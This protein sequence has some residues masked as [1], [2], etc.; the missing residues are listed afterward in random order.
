MPSKINLTKASMH[1][2]KNRH[3]F[4]PMDSI[5]PRKIVRNEELFGLFAVVLA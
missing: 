3:I 4:T 2:N 1:I 5:G